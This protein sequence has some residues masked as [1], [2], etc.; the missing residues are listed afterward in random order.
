LITELDKGDEFKR[1]YFLLC[2]D[3]LIEKSGKSLVDRIYDDNEQARIEISN[4]FYNDYKTL[5]AD[6]FQAL[7]ENNAE[8]EEMTLFSK[9]QKILDR[10]IFICFCENRLLLPK[11]IFKSVID[12]AKH[13]FV[14]ADNL[15]WEQLRGLFK[16]I[17]KGNPRIKINGYNGGLFEEDIILD[18]LDI[19]DKILERFAKLTGYDYFRP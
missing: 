19:P 15:L 11:G 3:N 1:F 17:D 8:I 6:L 9:A 12:A 16:S 13:S 2:K 7:K 18:S 4:E 14:L 5:R 10:F